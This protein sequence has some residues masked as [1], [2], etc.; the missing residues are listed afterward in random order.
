MDEVAVPCN[1]ARATAN[2]AAVP[3]LDE[4]MSFGVG[5]TNFTAS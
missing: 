3:A 5:T 1:A 2:H 4:P